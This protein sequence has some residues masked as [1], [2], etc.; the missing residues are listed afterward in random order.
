MSNGEKVN[1]SISH[2]DLLLIA[3]HAERKYNPET[4]TVYLS[5]K[6]PEIF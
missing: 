2:L 1:I 4:R 6:A 5:G 3:D